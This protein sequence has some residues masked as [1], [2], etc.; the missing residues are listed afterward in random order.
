M[1]HGHRRYV[2]LDGLRGVAAV[3]VV[4]SHCGHHLALPWLVGHGGFAVDVFF[5]MSGFVLHRSYGPRLR[6]G[7]RLRDVARAR[8]VRLYPLYAAGLL[9][10][11]CVMADYARRSGASDLLPILLRAAVAGSLLIPDLSSADGQIFPLN[12]P[13]WSLLVEVVVSLGYALGRGRVRPVGLAWVMGVPALGLAIVALQDQTLLAGGLAGTLGVSLSRGA[14]G[15]ATGVAIACAERRGAFRAIS[16]WPAWLAFAALCLCVM[17]PGDHLCGIL[18]LCIIVVVSPFIVV[19]AAAGRLPPAADR[20]C[21]A[22]GSLS[23]PLYALHA[24]VLFWIAK[25]LLPSLG[26]SPGGNLGILLVT[27]CACA[28]SALIVGRL[29]EPRLMTALRAAV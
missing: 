19:V 8:F 16:R 26:C 22:G 10:G 14:F 20:W 12:A 24:P 9:V 7:W 23:Y 11:L 6:E 25:I 21:R 28:G 5:V 1:D 18:D 13:S 29:V 4:L 17:V 27:T 2:A 15:F 3:A